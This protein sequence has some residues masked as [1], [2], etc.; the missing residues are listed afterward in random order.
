[1]KYIKQIRELDSEVFS[2]MGK[3]SQ[4]VIDVVQETLQQLDRD[5]SEEP[6]ERDELGAINYDI[7]ILLEIYN[8]KLEFDIYILK[9]LDLIIE[10]W[11]KDVEFINIA[12]GIPKHKG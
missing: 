3:T 5:S 6:I 9:K 4:I 1:M 11:Y 12:L 7:G 10:E 8:P 2:N